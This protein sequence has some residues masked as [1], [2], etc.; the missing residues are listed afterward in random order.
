[1]SYKKGGLNM[2]FTSVPNSGH[3]TETYK[4]KTYKYS[5]A[6]IWISLRD[7]FRSKGMTITVSE[8]RIAS[9]IP[10]FHPDNSEGRDKVFDTTVG[11]RQ[12][13]FHE[14]HSYGLINISM[15]YNICI[16]IYNNDRGKITEKSH[17]IYNEDSQHIVNIINYGN[18]HFEYIDKLIPE[19]EGQMQIIR[20]SHTTTSSMLKPQRTIF[21]RPDT[22]MSLM[23]TNTT[24][25]TTSLMLNPQRTIVRRPDTTT[26][27]I[28]TNTTTRTTSSML[29]PQRTIFSR[30]ETTIPSH[31]LDNIEQQLDEQNNK[32][33]EAI[34]ELRNLEKINEKLKQSLESESKYI[35]VC[36]ENMSRLGTA[37]NTN[38]IFIEKRNKELIQFETQHN[39]MLNE[40]QTSGRTNFNVL[41]NIAKTIEEINEI[42]KKT[43]TDDKSY[44]DELDIIHVNYMEHKQ[45]LDTYKKNLEENNE[46]YLILTTK[47]RNLTEE[48]SSLN[49]I[50]AEI[51]S[52][53]QGGGSNKKYIK[54]YL[55]YKKKLE[56][57]KQ[58]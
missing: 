45:L 26:S 17:F 6:C 4:G 54:K 29:Q 37:I 34:L 51:Y 49:A 19:T 46:K 11:I 16:I 18:S 3:I 53:Y 44:S 43:Q 31:D 40:L 15:K 27:L 47:I 28:P 5:N 55:Q 7:Y 58:N 10:L 35:S 56:L 9:E 42:I 2:E 23:P 20:P 48:L 25:R 14:N 21:S 22:T 38:N 36:N 33:T 32:L 39:K 52:Q 50:K 1:M 24:T 8:L 30:P 12:F 13:K 57:L 41:S